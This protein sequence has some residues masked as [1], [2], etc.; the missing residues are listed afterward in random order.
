M[1]RLSEA[2]SRSVIAQNSHCAVHLS[3]KLCVKN[4]RLQP[5]NKMPGLECWNFVISHICSC[6]LQI[7]KD[8]LL[9]PLK[10]Y[11]AAEQQIP[12]R[13][14]PKHLYFFFPPPCKYGYCGIK[15]SL[16]WWEYSAALALRSSI[17]E[18]QEIGFPDPFSLPRM[19][20]KRSGLICVRAEFLLIIYF[21]YVDFFLLPLH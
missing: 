3:H 11:W 21:I 5:W 14:G 16:G 12:W 19:M 18:G 1:E 8:A 13:I 20:P 9:S 10:D 17:K 4:T 6:W 2:G 7:Q 15:Y